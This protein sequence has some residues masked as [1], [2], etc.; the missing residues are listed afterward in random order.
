MHR[1]FVAGAAMLF[2]L[3]AG[4]SAQYRVD[5]WTTDNGLPQNSVT[6]LTRTPD[7]YIW[8]TTHDGLV[9]FDGNR[10]TIFNPSNTPLITNNRLSSAFADKSG[11]LWFGAEDGAVFYFQKGTFTMAAKPGELPDGPRSCFFDDGTGGVLLNIDHRPFVF[12][13]GTFIP[14]KV[15]GVP[16]NA[17][18]IFNDGDGEFWFRAEDSIYRTER[19]ETETYSIAGARNGSV[20][21]V[22]F[23]DS[24]GGFWAAFFEA[25]SFTLVRLKNGSVERIALDQP[26]NHFAEDAAGNLWLSVFSKGLYRVDH[27]DI[28]KE[29]LPSDAIKH[30]IDIDGISTNASG[31]LIFDGEG[32]LWV[33]TEK[34]LHRISPQVV[35][36]FSK[37]DG[38][39]NDNVYPIMA[40]SQGAVWAGVWPNNL[41]K[42]ENGRFRTWL[43][44]DTVLVTSLF[45]SGDGR[46]WYGSI[47]DVYIR[48]ND[49]STKFT[50]ESGFPPGTEFSAIT[51]D[52][53]GT[54]WF[55]TGSGLGSYK[56]G[57]TAIYT[58]ENGLPDDYVV[59]LLVSKSGRLWIGTRGGLAAFENG[60]I[61]S[62]TTED[63]LAS[64][65]I[66]SLYED[67][68]GVLWIGSYDGGLT[69]MKDGRF[70]V[71]MMRDGLWS[72]GVFCILED[73]D[74]W[75]WMN[76]NQGI[77]RVSRR[78]LNDF[79]DGKIRM[80]NSIAYTKKDGLLNIEGN[81]GRQP[82]GT[83]TPDGRLWFPTAAGI[84]VIDPKS[85]TLN[86]V[87]PPVIIED[88]LIDRTEVANDVFQSAVDHTGKITLEPGH[89]NLELNYTALSYINSEQLKF[90]YKLEGL[91]ADWNDVGTRRTAYYSYL[92]PGEYEF[93]VI[94]A[95]RDGIWNELGASLSVV[96]LPPFYRTWWFI[97]LLFAALAGVAALGYY[98][99]VRRLKRRAER[100][101]EF[102]RQLI[103]SQETERGRIAAEMHDG[104]G[105]SLAIIKNRAMISLSKPDDQDHSLE[106]LR[107][108]AEASN[109]AINEVH[110]IIYDL[111][112]IQLDRLGLTG[113]IEDMAERMAKT[114]EMKFD[115]SID[116]IDG[117]FPKQSENSVYR[118]IQESLN[119]V[120]KHAEASSVSIKVTKERSLVL[121]IIKD[122]GVGFDAAGS[123][124]DRKERGFGLN[125]MNERARLLGGRADVESWAG[126][127]TRVTVTLPINL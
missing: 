100:Q 30:V 101:E 63:G 121:I 45:D 54:M 83:R 15:P 47:G 107:E 59:A 65:S 120:V 3:C 33:G 67:A 117:I 51:R 5:S 16:E 84:A 29:N 88:A 44:D 23:K 90:R 73:D 106:Q 9:R 92:P 119:N 70:T 20:Y 8:F 24:T 39:Q 64:N 104:L 68:E 71:F 37:A 18:M 28:V 41:V 48:E 4:V 123:G 109:E 85:V 79:A 113:A 115:L 43:N 10:F 89:N 98:L 82:A 118:I 76:S 14:F 55:G 58:T 6:G 96:V 53:N 99:R 125:G 103:A 42:Y 1:A 21:E 60:K 31:H 75:F 114:S 69:R 38:L 61:K 36:V 97:G 111:R 66:R 40:D 80:L 25:D 108:I 12:A 22:A 2:V 50:T 87:P 78:E 72:N 74:G 81:G 49:R 13:D 56:D 110:G 46:L 91:D 95:N 126:A 102:T 94:A 122:D 86:Q 77:F 32:G 35:R 34:S 17:S 26:V 11:R 27:A 57:K 124:V 52:G 112:P 93:R 127:G 19:G 7:G 105:Q 62:Y 116:N